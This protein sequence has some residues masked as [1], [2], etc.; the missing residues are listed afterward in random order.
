MVRLVVGDDQQEIFA[1]VGFEEAD[2]PIG[3]AVAEGEFGGEV[4]IA[5]QR[6]RARAQPFLRGQLLQIVAHVVPVGRVP[7]VRAAAQPEVVAAVQVPFADIGGVD[8]PVMQP[9]ADRLDVVA[10]RVGIGPNAVGMGECAGEERRACRAADGLARVGAVEA[11]PLAGE[12]VEVGRVHVGIAVAP[13]HV[14]AL[15][16]GHDEDDLTWWH[17]Q[18]SD[19][20]EFGEQ[21]AEN[22]I[23]S[24]E[25]HCAYRVALRCRLEIEMTAAARLPFA[26]QP[27]AGD[28]A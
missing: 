26:H 4:R 14:L 21:I 13:D 16:V 25:P 10:H 3:A 22:G 1:L 23:A 17:T 8:A 9:L 15:G 12:P 19:V 18:F 28:H 27:R 5:V 7:A 24:H 2:R 6:G 11:H 20:L